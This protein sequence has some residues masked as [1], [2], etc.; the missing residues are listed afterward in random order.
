M[1]EHGPMLP[2]EVASK[3]QLN[4]F[5]AKAY[6]EELVQQGKLLQGEKIGS[7]P[8]FL[9]PG[10]EAQA[11][12]RAEE[13]LDTSRTVATHVGKDLDM[14]PEAVAKRE[15]FKAHFKKAMEP[16]KP[17]VKQVV[18]PVETKTEWKKLPDKIEE[19]KPK[20]KERLTRLFSPKKV[21]TKPVIQRQEFK[22]IK[23]KKTVRTAT[24]FTGYVSRVRRMFE[25]GKAKLIE[26][27]SE[28]KKKGK[29]VVD[30]PSSIGAVRYYVTV[31]DKKSINKSDIAL[32][33]T[34]ASNKKLPALLITNGK[35]ASGAEDYATDLG[36]MFKWKVLK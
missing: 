25:A 11:S 12:K 22:P 13:L 14:S 2:V 15:Q 1:Q 20:V 32:A 16:D 33:Y 27:I 30:F 24:V 5:L 18:K 36:G 9:L 28:K 8:I 10:Q 3:T 7:T 35:L 29:F 31:Y 26:E 4:S 21:E 23:V 6:M 34:E 17:K 19:E